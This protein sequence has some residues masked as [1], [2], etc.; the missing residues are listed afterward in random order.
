MKAQSILSNGPKV[1]APAGNVRADNRAVGR[2]EEISLAVLYF[3]PV[4]DRLPELANKRRIEELAASMRSSGQLQPIGVCPMVDGK[5]R[6]VFGHRRV[7]AARMLGWTEVQAVILWAKSE[8]EILEAREVENLQR[9]QYNPI[10]EA[11]GVAAMLELAQERIVGEKDIG[12]DDPLARAN[13]VS[14]FSRLNTHGQSVVR[15]AAFVYVAERIGKSLQWVKDRAYLSRLDG[16]ARKL[17]VDERLPLEHAIVI[18]RLADPGQRNELA[19]RAASDPEYGT[20][21]ME[22]PSLRELVAGQLYSLAQVP[23]LGGKPYAGKPACLTCPANSRNNPGLFADVG[24]KL[25][26][27]VNVDERH[28]AEAPY[29]EHKTPLA[30]ICTN[31]SCFQHKASQAARDLRTGARR[32]VKNAKGKPKADRDAIM[33][34][35]AREDFPSLRVEL[36]VERAVEL[37]KVRAPEKSRASAGS[38]PKTPAGPS[39]KEQAKIGLERAL[40]N[41]V[42]AIDDLLRAKCDKEPLLTIALTLLENDSTWQAACGFGHS[43]KAREKAWRSPRLLQFIGAL[44]DISLVLLRQFAEAAGNRLAEE[45]LPPWHLKHSD[46]PDR[47]CKV[48]GLTPPPMPK[49]ED[50]M[51]KAAAAVVVVKPKAG[52]KKGAK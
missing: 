27:P 52:K 5:H 17:V 11:M 42:E 26:Q 30:G 24:K 12:I 33:D 10:E 51:P 46:L 22:L 49:L 3:D 13:G 29:V 41:R 34:A 14:K 35:V 18:S 40:A 39:P 28:R 2:A 8:E 36:V 32:C 44:D 45:F 1:E 37:S 16:R 43:Q 4:G 19:E 9:E 6:V 25:D 20:Q 48:L 38:G 31:H 15:A 50:F 21:P 7:A 23:W 47:F